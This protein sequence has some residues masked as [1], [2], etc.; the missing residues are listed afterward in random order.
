MWNFARGEG[1]VEEVAFIDM[2]DWVTTRRN[3]YL[4]SLIF[5]GVFNFSFGK[6]ES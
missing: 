3:I 6:T 5:M 1:C 2:E 4:A